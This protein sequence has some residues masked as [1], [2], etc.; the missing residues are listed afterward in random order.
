MSER[1]AFEERAAIKVFDAGIEQGLAEGQAMQEV[2]ERR[3]SR[4]LGSGVV[5]NI[6]KE[7][8]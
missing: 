8:G 2:L 4:P 3:P 6:H 1:E 5:G 7:Q